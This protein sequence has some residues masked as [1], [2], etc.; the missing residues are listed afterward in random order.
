MAKINLLPTQA[1]RVAHNAREGWVQALLTEFVRMEKQLQ[2]DL[3]SS[4]EGR[5]ADTARGRILQVRDVMTLVTQ[6]G[7]KYGN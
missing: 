3:L 2:E 1:S 7:E 5:A 4:V 6:I